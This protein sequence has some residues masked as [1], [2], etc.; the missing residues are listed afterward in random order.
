MKWERWCPTRWKEYELLDSGDGEKLERF[1]EVT[2][3]RPEPLAKWD[4]S[5]SPKQWKDRAH[6]RFEQSGATS[7][8]WKS[9]QKHPTVWE[10]E[11]PS[12]KGNFSFE[13]QLTQFKHVGIFPEQASNWD[14]IQKACSSFTAE[15]SQP[16]VL[17]LFAY[18]GGASLAAAKAGAEVT[19][20]DSIKQVLQWTQRN[21]EISEIEGVRWLLDDAL[22]FAQREARRGNRYQGLIMDPPAWGRGPKGERWKLETKLDEL[23]ESTSKILAPDGFLVLNTYSGISLSTLNELCKKYFPN[24]QRK[25]GLLALNLDKN[26]LDTGCVVRLNG[27]S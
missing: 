26:K 5:L 8:K 23:L 14:F 22:K 7:G 9:L 18:T 17:N 25:V 13:L 20:V 16:K 6:A 2:L 21:I 3:I 19:H 15:G 1:G 4:K 12:L 24:H 27:R 11:Y 10:L